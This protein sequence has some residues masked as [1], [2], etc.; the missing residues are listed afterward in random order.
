MSANQKQELPMVT[1]FFVQ[2]DEIRKSYRG[3]SIDVSCKMLL[4]L[5]EWFQRRRL[6]EID[7]PETRI[8]ASE[9]SIKLKSVRIINTENFNIRI[10]KK[11]IKIC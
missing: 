4:Y 7:Q 5:S 3:P 9:T 2:S 8:H 10:I 1:M 6:S 11:I